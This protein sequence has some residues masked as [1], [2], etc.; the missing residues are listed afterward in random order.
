MKNTLR[1]IDFTFLQPQETGRYRKDIVDIYRKAFAH[2]PYNEGESSVI[3]FS[4][5]FD[6]HLQRQGYRCIVARPSAK[7]PIIGFAFGYTAQPGQWWR[8]TVASVLTPEQVQRWLS[9][10]F[11]LAELA[12]APAFQGRGIGGKL[13]DTLLANLTHQT[14]ALSTIQAESNALHLYRK[15]GYVTLVKDLI[16]PGGFRNYT[17]MSLD[18]KNQD[19]REAM[20]DQPSPV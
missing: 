4:V 10:C 2:P 12:V 20:S 8:D 16:F 18:L 1:E 19:L 9:D 17:I 11:E 13:H 3:R 5:A 15:R 7:G 6:R 14:A